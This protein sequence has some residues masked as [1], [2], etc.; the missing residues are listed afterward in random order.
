M[1]AYISTKQSLLRFC[2]S[3]G[4]AAGVLIALGVIMGGPRLGPH[5]D[6]LMGLRQPPRVSREILL[7]ETAGAGEDRAGPDNIIEPS[8]VAAVLMTLTE[9]NGSALIVQAPVLGN[10]PGTGWDEDEL[11][12][13]FNI[14]FSLLEN[15]IRNLFEAIRV[16]SV[17]PEESG[18][19]VEDLTGLAERGKERLLSALLHTDEAGMRLFREAAAAFGNL[20]EA[21]DLRVRLIRSGASGN[22]G[23]AGGDIHRY[24]KPRPDPDGVFRRIA[25]VMGD[26]DNTEHIL[27]AALK[28]RLDAS[29]VEP[30]DRGPVLRLRRDGVDTPLPLDSR[31]EMLVDMPRGEEDFKRLPLETFIAYQGADRE[32]YWMLAE[33]EAKGFYE[34]LAPEAYPTVLYRYADSLREEMLAAPHR[35]NKDRWLEA[36]KGYL[37]SLEAFFYGPTEMELAAGYEGLLSSETLAEAGTARIIALR[38][39]LISSFMNIRVAY[40]ELLG[41]RKTLQDGAA[42][43]ICILGSPASGQGPSDIET[44]AMLANSLLTGQVIIPLVNRYIFFWS[45]AAALASALVLRKWGPAA[46]LVTG[47]LC[48]C[49]TALVFIAGFILTPYWIDPVIPVSGV[50]GAAAS[51][52]VCALLLKRENREFFR[53]AYGPVIAP[54]YLRQVI[55]AR[56]P[57][58]REMVTAKAALVAVRYGGFAAAENRSDPQASA[59]AAELFRQEVSAAFKNAGGAMVGY[60]GDMALA[61]FGSP[62]ERAALRK[63]KAEMPYEDDSQPRGNHSPAAKA[64]GFILD[65]LKNNPK[66]ASWHFGVDAGEC[67]FTYSPSAGYS[68]FGPAAIRA[69]L[70]SNISPRYKARIIVTGRVSEKIEGI[71]LKRLG[72]LPDGSGKDQEFFYALLAK[73][74][75]GTR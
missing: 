15:N 40:G 66:A 73:Q 74:D 4:A 67:A 23:P 41:I 25:P 18:R 62:L 75:N 7:I 10:S 13:R 31:G 22:A 38:D 33:A 59:R 72:A 52:F 37:Q 56:R 34:T 24:S 21:G 19:Y 44:S 43:S 46:T 42:S 48:I 17:P 11:L 12:R 30:T 50:T 14:E 26:E 2:L 27:Y 6:I 61:A 51:S 64:V 60:D 55:R 45:L 69:R 65:L 29:G 9:L 36:R 28:T 32:L 70:L 47:F 1:A 20:W 5:Y 63:M 49:L 58:P 68:V 8:V 71:A 54:A 3:L 35:D 53:R 57:L 16:G 39:E